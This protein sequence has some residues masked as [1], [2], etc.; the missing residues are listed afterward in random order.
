MKKM[1]RLIIWGDEEEINKILLMADFDSYEE[2]EAFQRSHA[3]KENPY[4]IQTLWKGTKEIRVK[5]P[6]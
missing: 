5:S 6:G 2:A 1:Y 4:N 3:L